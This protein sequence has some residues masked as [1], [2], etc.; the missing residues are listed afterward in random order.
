MPLK[1]TNWRRISGLGNICWVGRVRGEQ[2][3]SIKRIVAADRSA[4][5]NFGVSGSFSNYCA[6]RTFCPA[7]YPRSD[8]AACLP[9]NRAPAKSA[10]AA[11]TVAARTGSATMA[12]T[13]AT[14]Y[15]R[16]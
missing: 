5:G 3:A 12:R 11:V 7:L 9:A 4:A 14:A 10:N 1:A 8:Y 16:H 15:R 2:G 6:N 13:C